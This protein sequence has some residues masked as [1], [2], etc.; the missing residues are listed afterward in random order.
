MDSGVTTA[1]GLHVGFMELY[2]GRWSFVSNDKHDWVNIDDC[3]LFD[4]EA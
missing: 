3:E 2:S 4:D 1:F